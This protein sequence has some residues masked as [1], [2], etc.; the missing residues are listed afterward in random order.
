[1]GQLAL[2][3]RRPRAF[4]ADMLIEWTSFVL[5]A[6]A[7]LGVSAGLG[8]SPRLRVIGHLLLLGV[9]MRIVGVLARHSMIFDLYGGGS[10]AVGYFNSGAAIAKQ[11]RALDFSVIGSDYW[12]ERQWG[13]QA[14]RYASGFVIALVGRSIRGAFLVFSLAAY[15][16]L[17][18]SAVAFGRVNSSVSTPRA[19]ALLFLWPT[20]WFWPSS[21]GKEAILLLAVG[22]VTLGYVGRGDRLHWIPLIS[23]LLLAMSIR[24]HI[25]GVLAVSMCVAE[26]V[27]SGWTRRRVTQSLLVSVLG[28]ALLVV[29]LNTLGLTNPGSETFE[30]FVLDAAAR[31]NQGG[32]AFERADSTAVAIPMAFISILCRPFITEAHNPMALVS[33]L[34]MMAFWMLVIYRR[35]QL[36]SGLRSWRTN[37]LMRFVIPF[38][39][40]YVLM[41][42]LTFQNLG[43]IARQRTL[44]MPALLLLLAGAESVRQTVRVDVPQLRR[45]WRQPAPRG[46]LG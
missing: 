36:W 25:A 6:M 10:D 28:L 21:I 30:T 5:V 17:V 1:M 16:G 11:F 15:V 40:L 45:S 12:G 43:I 46:S 38:S 23:G 33:S 19:A 44:V 9:V 14:V 13:T 37:R 27:A 34:E 39:L 31:T 2:L 3:H 20:L 18:C 41:I 7:A 4:L 42:G 29:A 32:G 8:S 24:P 35:R 22:L 26:W